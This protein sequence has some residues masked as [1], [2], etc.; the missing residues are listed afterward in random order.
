[1]KA[2]FVA[3]Q[4]LTLCPWPKGSER[5]DELG[6]SAFFFP[7]VGFILGSILV[8]VN[9]LLEPFA[10]PGLLSVVLVAILAVLTG[11]LHLDGVGDTFDGLGA[12]GDRERRLSIM[13]DSRTGTFG[14]IA[15]VLVLLFKIHALQSMEVDRWRVLLVAPILGRWA[16]V[17]LGYRSEAAKPGLGSNLV[18]HLEMTRFLLATVLTLLLVVAIWRANGI[19]MMAWVA[20]FTTA[21][22]IYFHRRLGGVTGDTFGAVGELSETSVMVLL[23]L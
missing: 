23:A 13:D 9:F 1:M 17:L 10:S 6:R 21:S 15:I 4:F 8:L 20:V 14:L 11:G 16:M 19:V 5:S 2:F 3:L 18:D 22:K 7:L 12:G